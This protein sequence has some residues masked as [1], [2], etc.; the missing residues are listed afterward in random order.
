MPRLPDRELRGVD[1]DREAARTGV[2]VVPGQGCLVTL[3]QRPPRGQRQRVG[4]DDPAVEQVLSE[5]QK[6]PSRCS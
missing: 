2:D 1:A 6:L 3:V 5:V 4:G